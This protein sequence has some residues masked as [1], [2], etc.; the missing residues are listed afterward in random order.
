MAIF[1][2]YRNL[3]PVTT[4]QGVVIDPGALWKHHFNKKFFV[5]VDEDEYLTA[6]LESNNF[7]KEE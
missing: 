6:D 4:H 1:S 5:L 3:L 2:Y 7:Q